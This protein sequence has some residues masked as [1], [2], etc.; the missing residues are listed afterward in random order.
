VVDRAALG[1]VFSVYFGF[2]CHSFNRL[3]YA[4]RQT[5]F[6]WGWYNSPFIGPSNSVLGSTRAKEIKEKTENVAT[7]H[8]MRDCLHIRGKQIRVE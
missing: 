5:S 8:I 6:T 2:P 7:N 1:Q 4:H 3:L